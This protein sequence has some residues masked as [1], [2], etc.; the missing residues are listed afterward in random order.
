M[1]GADI[2]HGRA[3]IARARLLRDLLASDVQDYGPR[4]AEITQA[5][6]RL[7][8][9]GHPAPRRFVGNVYVLT[10]SPDRAVIANA[11]DATIAPETLT[12][13]HFAAAFAAWVAD[14]S[15]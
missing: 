2:A 4:I 5:L 10:L 11:Q 8:T 13:A 6:D 12:L 7:R 3:V 1:T 9:P 14:L 15:A